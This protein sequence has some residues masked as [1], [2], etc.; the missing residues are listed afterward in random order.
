MCVCVNMSTC[1]CLL[2]SE[3]HKAD[4]VWFIYDAQILCFL[5]SSSSVCPFFIGT[6]DSKSALSDSPHVW[7]ILNPCPPES[8]LLFTSNHCSHLC[9]QPPFS[10]EN[11]QT[12]VCTRVTFLGHKSDLS[13]IFCGLDMTLDTLANWLNSDF[14]IMT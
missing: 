10:T 11:Y 5:S 13:H 9:V 6:H 3:S 14:T 8:H 7:V 1:K 2:G 4:C 12:E